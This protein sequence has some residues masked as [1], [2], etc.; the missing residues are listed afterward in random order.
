L[1][2]YKE[3]TVLR[4]RNLGDVCMKYIYIY[5]YI[6]RQFVLRSHLCTT[7]PAFKRLEHKRKNK[8]VLVKQMEIYM[9]QKAKSW[10]LVQRSPTDCGAS[11]CLI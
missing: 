6:Y 4:L 11:L 3:C 7:V 1:V 8:Y 2:I 10:S 9:Q 5:I